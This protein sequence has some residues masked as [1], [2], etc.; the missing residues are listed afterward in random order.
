MY[1]QANPQ[2]RKAEEEKEELKHKYKPGEQVLPRVVVQERDSEDERMLAE[3]REMSL[4]E[5]DARGAGS[6]ERGIRH[7]TAERRRDPGN[8]TR[9][10]R[11][12]HRADPSH[13]E[14]PR[15]GAHRSIGHQSSL[16]SLMSNSEIDSSE[17]EEEILRLVDEGWLD[18]IDLDSL[19]TS[20]VDELS[21]R[22]A[23]AYRRRHGHRSRAGAPVQAQ[24]F[25]LGPPSSMIEIAGLR[26]Q[27]I[28]IEID[29]EGK[30]RLR[31]RPATM[32]PQV[33]RL[34]RDLSQPN[35]NRD[36]LYHFGLRIRVITMLK[37]AKSF[38]NL[39]T[40]PPRPVILSAH[41]SQESRLP[42]QR[43]CFIPN[44][45][46]TSVCDATEWAEDVFIALA[47][48]MDPSPP[49]ALVGQQYK[50][51]EPEVIQLPR[52]TAGLKM[53]TQNPMDLVGGHRLKND[54]NNA[55]QSMMQEW[56]WQD[57]QQ[58][59][60]R[61]ISSQV[62]SVNESQDEGTTAGPL[63][64]RY[65]PSGGMGMRVLA[66]WTYLPSD[67]GQDELSFPKGAEI[68][69]VENINDDW[70]VGCYAGRSGLFPGNYV[71]VLDT[72]KA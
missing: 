43:L 46:L 1:L 39:D 44:R 51:P 2:R 71:R 56:S 50:R 18:G 41:P 8:N 64:R 31:F 45:Q 30:L 61:A 14:S 34:P 9:Q 33:M 69:E 59:H 19:D 6:Y 52:S 54:G 38:R 23:N 67:E 32:C 12:H 4:R 22:I 27:I 70:F 58:R 42:L 7:R 24:L 26:T 62:S 57:G 35:P 37:V 63:L 49:H 72:V 15:G 3:A 65:P 60:V 11:R 66:L 48:G 20:Q 5:V 25:V 68:Q 55:E 29:Q 40:I 16:R 47:Q 21:E 10:M 28:T 13:Q 17:M 36:I 53:V